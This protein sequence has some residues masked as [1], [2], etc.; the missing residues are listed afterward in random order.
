MK[1]QQAE[2]ADLK[3]QVYY[4]VRTAFLDLESSREQM[5][6]ATRGRELA[7]QQLEQSRDRFA[8]GVAN[9]IEVVQAQEAVALATDQ[10]ISAV[11]G[12]NIAKALLAQSVG[13]AEDAVRK[14]LEVLR[15]EQ[16]SSPHHRGRRGHDSWRRGVVALTAGH[17]STDDAQV[18]A[19]VTPVAARVGGTILS[20]PAPDNQLVEA[21]ALLAQIDPRDYEIALT[22]AEAELANAQAELAAAPGANVPITAATATSSVSN[23]HGGL[24]QPTPASPRPSRDS[25]RQRR[26]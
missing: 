18:E 2:V 25:S 15:N 3:A 8:A 26:S 1:R 12:V 10:Y 7:A 24:A 13:T 9:N 16:A 5:T 11:Y 6:T 20:V 17:E 21:G 23:A 14:A 4:D 19:H 22:H